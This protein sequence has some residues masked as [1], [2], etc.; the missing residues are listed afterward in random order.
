MR[1]LTPN[2]LWLLALALPIIALYLLRLHRRETPVASVLLWQAAAVERR[3]NRPWQKLRRHW[4]LALQLLILATL[5]VAAARPA[6]PAPSTPQGRLLILLD[7]SASMQ[8]RR[9]DGN[10]RFEAALAELRTLSEA[11]DARSRVTLITAS[12]APQVALRD[13]DAA[14]LRRTLPALQPTDG[15]ANWDAAASLALGLAVGEEVTTLVFTD[16]ALAEPLPPLPGRAQLFTVGEAAPNVGLVDFSLRRSAETF[17]AFV[18]VLNAGPA[19]QV[20]LLLL[21]GGE[22][23]A[24][25]VLELP[26]AGEATLSFPDLPAWGWFEA[27]LEDADDRF[28]LDDRA[29]VTPP[30]SGSG[31]VLLVTSGNRFLEL[32]LR[33]LPGIAVQQATTLPQD[34]AEMSAVVLDGAGSGGTFSGPAWLIAPGAGTPCGEPTGV[35]TPTT[36]L[37]AG[38]HPLLEYVTWDDVHIARATRYAAPADAVTLLE[39][40]EGPLLWVL[41]RPGQRLVCQA[42]ALQD[43]DL[44]LRVAFPI[45]TNNLMGWLLPQTSQAP[46]TSL[47]AGLPWTPALPLAATAA[48]LVT[49]TGERVDLL[50]ATA[51][52]PQRAGLYRLEWETAGG[53]ATHYVAL[54][55]LDAAESDLHPHPLMIEGQVPLSAASGATGWRDF[56]RWVAAAAL[57][58]L[59]LEGALW[60]GRAAAWHGARAALSALRYDWRPVALR[61]ILVG[62]LILALADVRLPQATRNLATVFVVDRSASVAVEEGEIE[63]LLTAAWEAKGAQDRAAVVVF[64]GEARGAQP[65]SEGPFAA[66]LRLAPQPDATDIAAAVRLGAS[67]VPEGAPGRLVLITD[68]LETRGDG[69]TALLQARER[70]LETL[71]AAVT[72]A[73]SAEVWIEA[74]RLPA[75]AYPGDTV[76]VAVT[77]GA[78]VAQPVRLTWA[79]GAQEGDAVWEVS[80]GQGRYLFTFNAPERGWVPVRFCVAA[81]ADSFV[82][83]NCGGGWLRVEGAPRVLVVGAVEERRALAAALRATGLEVVEL[84]PEALPFT[85]PALSDYAAVVLVNTPARALPLQAGSALRAYVRDLGGGLVTLGGPESY[86]V[87]GW[88]VTALEAALPV[89]TQVQDPRRFPPLAMVVVIDKSGSMAAPDAEGGTPKIR[90]AAEAA[91]RVSEALNDNDALAVVAYDDRPAD[92][93]GPVSGSER[94]LLIGRL[95]Q[96]Q[97]GG[98]GIYV[99]DGLAYARQLLAESFEALSEQ[100]R[101]VLLVADG[102]DAEQQAGALAQVAA[103]RAQGAMVSVI[104]IG[105]GGDVP[106]LQEVAR[107]GE[108]RFYLTER[109]ADLPVIFTEELA[110]ARRSYLVEQPFF[111]IA[112]TAWEPLESFT[113]LP[114]LAGYVATTPK[115][116]ADVPLWG[117]VTG[118]PLLA[119]W[120]YGLGRA[121]AWTSDA[122]GRWAVEWLGWEDFARFWGDVVRWVLPVPAEEGVALNV[123]AENG[124]ARVTLDVL[125]PTTG[126]YVDGLDL[127]L[128]ASQLEAGASVPPTALRQTAPGRYETTLPLGDDTAPWLFHV[129]GAL[130]ATAGWMPP[131]ATEFVPGDAAAATA[132]LIARGQAQPLTA[133]EQT[134]APTLRGRQAGAPLAPWLVTAVAWLWPLDIAARRLGISWDEVRRWGKR[135]RKNGRRESRPASRS[136]ASLP[137]ES[138]PPAS[139]LPSQEEALAARLKERL[140]TPRR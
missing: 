86:G 120:Q 8:A 114:A 92:T 81:E 137:V 95:S 72:P 132:R 45:L 30:L 42:F 123:A 79:A 6:V 58:L 75:R 107:Q 94:Q 89:S 33:A 116:G 7:A 36:P 31:Q 78:T 46:I 25:Q 43:S 63:A 88:S 106:F 91:A 20:T 118:D 13:G 87:G 117:A 119:A 97:A 112:G 125:D 129:T 40:A 62:A 90:L 18:R 37:R 50:D 80:R 127:V 61:L 2:S 135:W 130:Q 35:F 10:T 14:A 17:T 105:A 121:V 48:V 74:T 44:P 139:P 136:V 24:R 110:H 28:P 131:Y 128:Q 5:V 52:L 122:T 108:G 113:A 103:L 23:L 22:V 41:N 56:S 109:A 99:R 32:A 3:A 47:P 12:A 16:A 93:L 77:L 68:G 96:L 69:A 55:L 26:A 134:F 126:R 11:L 83:N 38:S 98:G 76:A 111:P 101:L 53:P 65:L 73:A 27:R 59:L 54:S 71:V 85:A 57:A 138:S 124:Q 64:G 115:P 9:E 102:S 49:P 1:F 140:R 133:P 19:R 15:G 39:T 60:W 82:E 66:D 100:Q 34:T 104:A 70:G 4:L 84:Q 51:S 67:L 29:W 21:A